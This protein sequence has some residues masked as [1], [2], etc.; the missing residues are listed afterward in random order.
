MDE[1][2]NSEAEA[3][4][5]IGAGETLK[6]AREAKGM[7]LAQLAS[8][9][10]IPQR[11]LEV[12]ESGDFA[13]LPA[14]TYAI[15][16]SRTYAKL[17]GLDD[18]EI[19]DMVRDELALDGGSRR[20]DRGSTFEPGDPAKI[21]SAGLA[22]AGGIAA[23]LLLAGAVAFY[24]RYYGAGTGPAPLQPDPPAQVVRQAAPVNGAA[25]QGQLPATGGQVVFTALEDGIWVRFFDADGKRLLEKQMNSGERFEIP[26]DAR[27]P[28]IN[29]G[30]PDAFAIT[31][32]GREVPKLSNDPVTIGDA[33]VSAAALLARTDAPAG[34]PATATPN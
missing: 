4:P 17:V 1:E 21:P 6:R 22:W 9:S 18:R 10:R 33:P 28:R 31:V 5:R 8:E 32:G 16:F 34:A 23:V 14:R 3:H 24:S 30:R 19:S 25:P 2:T 29:T 12:I 26:T 27:E 20:P 13:A 15:G 7:T 11:H